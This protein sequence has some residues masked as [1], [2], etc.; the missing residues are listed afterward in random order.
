M[1]GRGAQRA[2]QPTPRAADPEAVARLHL[3]WGWFMLLVFV[4]LGMLLEALHGFKIGWYLD[5]GHEARRLMFRLGHAH[6]TLL[7]LLNLGLAFTVTRLVD[8][9]ARGRMLASR[10]LRIASVLM[11]G[12]FLGGGIVIHDGDP[13]LAVVLVPVGAAAL[14]L[15]VG[16]MAWSTRGAAG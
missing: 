3:R 10:G 1:S 12:G 6:G 15:A 16:V 7:G 11:P 5:V 13:G 14:V 4:L 9:P 8:Q 2:G